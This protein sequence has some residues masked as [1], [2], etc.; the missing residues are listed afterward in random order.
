MLFQ[1]KISVADTPG[2]ST[3]SSASTMATSLPLV[4]KNTEIMAFH[5]KRLGYVNDVPKNLQR[6]PR[7][8]SF[9]GSF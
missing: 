4:D 1:V 7:F 3:N 2:S 8:S 6:D 9:L 5:A